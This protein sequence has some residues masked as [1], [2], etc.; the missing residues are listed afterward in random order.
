[1]S[2]SRCVKKQPEWSWVVAS[3][4]TPAVARTVPGTWGS[5]WGLHL[6][7]VRIEL[8]SVGT[9]IE[10]GSSITIV[11]SKLSTIF[12]RVVDPIIEDS[13]ERGGKA[14]AFGGDLR[15]WAFDGST[16]RLLLIYKYII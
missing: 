15:T 4:G 5:M 11:K 3:V 7:F 10:R 2:F 1:M 8:Y 14:G 16:K 9:K 6:S 13:L 12:D